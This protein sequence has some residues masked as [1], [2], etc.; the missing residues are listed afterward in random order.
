MKNV[1]RPDDNPQDDMD[2]SLS[3]DAHQG[4][5][6]GCL[7]NSTAHDDKRLGYLSQKTNEESLLWILKNEVDVATETV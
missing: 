6:E 5:C 2:P 3:S 1:H 4:D 7:P